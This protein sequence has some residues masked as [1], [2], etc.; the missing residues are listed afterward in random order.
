MRTG[1][2][3]QSVARAPRRLTGAVKA[4][5]ALANPIARRRVGYMSSLLGIA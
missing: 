5:R 1:R 3:G 2:D 4:Q